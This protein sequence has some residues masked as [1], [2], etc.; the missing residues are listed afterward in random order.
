M[1][2]INSIMK[3]AMP[4]KRPTKKQMNW[5]QAKA[6]YPK[7]NPLGNY[8][9]DL[10]PNVIDCKPFDKTKQEWVKG[11]GWRATNKE[12]KEAYLK[13][14]E[15]GVSPTAA[16]RLR[17]WRPTKLKT[18]LSGERG[19]DFVKNIGDERT[20]GEREYR[21]ELYHKNKKINEPEALKMKQEKADEKNRLREED[22]NRHKTEFKRLKEENYVQVLQPINNETETEEKEE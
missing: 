8:D 15:K 19:P 13:L 12:R 4:I 21:R 9:N 2:E 20:E 5:K 14:R 22:Y 6:K 16:R 18:I 11:L 7:L 17:S 1:N 3:M 10:M